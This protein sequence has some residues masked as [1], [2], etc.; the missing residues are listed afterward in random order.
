[1]K[2]VLIPPGSFLMGSPK[3]EKERKPDETRHKVKLEKGFYMGT[4]PVTQEQ[5][6]ELMGKNPG[7]FQD[8]KNL[9]V[10]QVNWNDCQEFSKKLRVKDKKPYRL[11][12]EAEWEYACR[13]GVP[14]LPCRSLQPYPLPPI[15]EKLHPCQIASGLAWHASRDPAPFQTAC[16]LPFSCPPQL[17]FANFTFDQLLVSV[18]VDTGGSADGWSKS[19]LT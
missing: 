1:M 3:E 4:C 13:A 6:K 12:T 18:H 10:E 11:P 19:L 9:P 5:W 14:R 17:S 7:K 15:S 2:F 8:D 16:S